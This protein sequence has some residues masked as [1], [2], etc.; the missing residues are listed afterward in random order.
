MCCC[1]YF[2]PPEPAQ[3]NKQAEINTLLFFNYKIYHLFHHWTGGGFRRR[4]RSRS[5][6]PPR[7]YDDDRRERSLPRY[8][9]RRERSPPRYRS[10]SPPPPRAVATAPAGAGG[11]GSSSGRYDDY[12]MDER[13]IRGQ[14][15]PG[16]YRDRGYRP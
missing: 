6:S 9:D 2:S 1:I 12:R 11:R 3:A 16:G 7:R 14:S 4:S 8:H 15:P 13:R 5:R 10:D